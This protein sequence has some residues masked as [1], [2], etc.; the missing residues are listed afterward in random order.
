M[1]KGWRESTELA[2]RKRRMVAHAKAGRTKMEAC[3]IEGVDPTQA[4]R[5][6]TGSGVSFGDHH[7]GYIPVGITD[8]NVGS[9]LKIFG[10]EL[11][12]LADDKSPYE[13]S[14]LT[15]LTL[16]EQNR[17]KAASIRPGHVKV[18]NWTIGQ[19]QRLAKARN[20]TLGDL[21]DHASKQITREKGIGFERTD[22]R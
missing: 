2:K 11:T 10:E 20:M 13:V 7:K 6:L 9:M 1:S 14:R 17:A 18:H 19:L 4:Q 8:A 5:D 15:G 3:D 16:S 12:R 21:L 22:H